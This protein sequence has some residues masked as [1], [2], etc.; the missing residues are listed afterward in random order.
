MLHYRWFSLQLVIC[1]AR[2]RRTMSL[3]NIR[4]VGCGRSRGRIL[5]LQPLRHCIDLYDHDLGMQ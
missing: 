2:Q 5:R 3:L 4:M 1:L